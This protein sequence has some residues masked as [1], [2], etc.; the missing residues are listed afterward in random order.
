MS[1]HGQFPFFQHSQA[2][3]AVRWDTHMLYFGVGRGVSVAVA[4]SQ[5]VGAFDVVQF[6][7]ASGMGGGCV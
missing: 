3:D 2:F 7:V 5:H 6:G 4:V 1:L